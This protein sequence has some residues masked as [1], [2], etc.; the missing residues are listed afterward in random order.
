MHMMRLWTGYNCTRGVE[1]SWTALFQLEL[2]A[3]GGMYA[4]NLEVSA[5]V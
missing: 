3:F 4:K 2:T 1:L 5:H